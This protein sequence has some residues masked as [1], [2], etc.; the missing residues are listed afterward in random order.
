MGSPKAPNPVTTAQ[1][2]GE[3]NIA[4]A[5]KSTELN[6]YN[7]VNPF[8][9]STWSTDPNNPDKY[10]LTQEM[11]PQIL[12]NLKGSLNL[13]N[14]SN[15]ISGAI[16]NYMA[17]RLGDAKDVLDKPITA[18]PGRDRAQYLSGMVDERLYDPNAQV[19][20]SAGVL[21][22]ANAANKSNINRMKDLATTEMSFAGAP[23][24][25]TSDETTRQKVSDAIYN[26]ATSRLD[27][28]FEQAQSDLDAKLAAQGITQGSAA[29][30]R[31][32]QN[33][34]M[35]RNDAYSNAMYDA[36]IG[37]SDALS[38]LFANQLNA[39]K[40]GVNEVDMVRDQKLDEARLMSDLTGQATGNLTGLSGAQ[41]SRGL[42]VPQISGALL[43]NETMG[44]NN[45]NA[46]RDRV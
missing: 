19:K 32:M 15:D 23:D 30:D 4:A 14:Q 24:M 8:G 12:Q 43:A 29:Y 34:A 3:A 17:S 42:A 33:M 9:S 10:T 11:D 1:A 36:E 13:S 41:T 26:R 39:R 27:P 5:R 35:D 22:T 28:R 2:Q 46:L 7:E 18:L 6:R 31:E 25:P 37:S 16:N 40:Q 20:S 44:A 45:E 21:D 38:Q